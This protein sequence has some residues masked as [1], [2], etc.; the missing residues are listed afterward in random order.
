MTTQIEQ[1]LRRC[2]PDRME[3]VTRETRKW[4]L[5]RIVDASV[6]GEDIETWGEILAEMTANVI[7]ITMTAAAGRTDAEIEQIGSQL[8]N[9]TLVLD[10]E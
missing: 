5:G 10:D 7:A 8:I 9:G 4:A 2:D 3:R 1:L 6:D